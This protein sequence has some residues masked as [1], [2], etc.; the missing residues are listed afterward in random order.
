MT[1]A[2]PERRISQV[3]RS[4]CWKQLY[5]MNEVP[6][7]IFMRRYNLRPLSLITAISTTELN[8]AMYMSF[9]PGCTL[10]FPM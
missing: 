6:Q 8:A 7:I 2:V 3:L 5:I 10:L 1:Y 9:K 4:L